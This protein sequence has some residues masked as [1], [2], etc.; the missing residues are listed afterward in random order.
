MEV[1]GKLFGGEGNFLMGQLEAPCSCF[2][3]R[4]ENDTKKPPVR[5]L[6]SSYLIK[7]TRQDKEMEV[8]NNE[9][10]EAYDK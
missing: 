7:S 8:Q 2:S 3:P 6:L 1:K 10:N 9:E 5:L 4:S